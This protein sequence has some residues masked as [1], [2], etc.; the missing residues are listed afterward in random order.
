MVMIV[1][2]VGRFFSAVRIVSRGFPRLFDSWN[3]IDV[4]ALE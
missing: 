2:V 4:E 1:M 3:L